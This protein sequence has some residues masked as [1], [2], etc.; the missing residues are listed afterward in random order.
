MDAESFRK[1]M[2]HFHLRGYKIS[3]EDF[4]KLWIKEYDKDVTWP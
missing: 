3:D 4:K 2:H 1:A